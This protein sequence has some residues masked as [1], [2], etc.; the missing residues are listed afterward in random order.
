M[1]IS[2]HL[3]SCLLIEE[4]GKTILFDPGQYTYDEKALNI[5]ALEKL[6]HILITH[7]HFD[8]MYA[9][10]IKKVLAKFPNATVISNTSVSNILKREGI[11]V[12]TKGNE[13]IELK[14]VPHEKT[15]EPERP[16]NILF[17]LF[18]RFSDP[19]DSH[20]FSE[21]KEIL[22]LPIQ[23]PWGSFFHAIELAVELKPK[24]IIPIHDW[25]WKDEVRKQF[26]VRSKEYLAGFGID[27]KPMETGEVIEIHE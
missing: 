13:Y 11:A 12:E 25:H 8:H 5:D 26:Y 19:G 16:Q 18:N 27:F 7:E 4:Q 14:L 23:A 20:S 10:L 9:P 21:T 1:K 3:H 2:K 17:H 24:V 22:A 15:F 6:D